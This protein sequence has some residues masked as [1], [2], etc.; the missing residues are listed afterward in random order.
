[1]VFKNSIIEG[2]YKDRYEYNGEGIDGTI[3][4]V[5]KALSDDTAHEGRLIKGMTEGKLFGAGRVMAGAGIGNGVTL[6]NCFTSNF[7]PDSMRGIFNSVSD[8]AMVH[9]LGGGNGNEFSHIR[10]NGSVTS[11]GAVASGVV[12]FMDVF[13]AQTKT[14]MVGSRRGANMGVLSV[15]HPD[16]FEY[17]TAKSKD[18]NRLT[19]FNLSVMVD[20][21][22]MEAVDNNET[23]TLRFPVYNE[24]G[25]LTTSDQWEFTKVVDANEIWDAIMENA[26]NYGEPG[27]LYYD[28]MNN[29]NN[30]R[31]LEKIVVTNPCGEFISGVLRDYPK[32][33]GCCN[34]SS[35]YLHMFVE[36]PFTKDA[37]FNLLEMKQSAEDIV[38]MLD[39]VVDRNNYPDEHFEQYQQLLRTLGVGTTGLGT[40]LQMMGYAYG[41]D[42]AIAFVDDL[43]NEIAK[44]LYRASIKLAK[45]KGSFELFDADKFC[46]SKFLQSHMTKDKEWVGIVNDIKKYGIRNARLISIAP[47][48]TTSMAFGNNCSSGIE[49]VFMHS[50]TRDM[51][52]GGQTEDDKVTVT[53]NDYGY[54][55]YLEKEM[56]QGKAL[57]DI[58]LP[59]HFVTAMELTVHQHVDMLAAIAQH[60]DMAISK[61][62]NVPEDYPF[63]DAKD[64][65]M[66]AWKKGIKGVTIFRPNPLRAGIFNAPKK[67]EEVEEVKQVGL[68]WGTTIEA[69]DDL[70]GRKRK[71]QTGCGSLHIHAFF[72]P[73]SG[74]LMEVF[75]NKGGSGG[76][77]GYAGGL[78]RIISLALRT[79]AT[80][81]S[82]AEQLNS[83]MG[84][85]SYVVRNKVFGD[86]ARGTNCSGAIGN[87]LKQ[88]QKEI[89]EEM[90]G[91]E[92]EDENR[93][94]LEEVKRF[95][96]NAK[97]NSTNSSI[98]IGTGTPKREIT[99]TQ[100]ASCGE[101]AYTNPDGCG[102]CTACGYSKCS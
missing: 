61:T 94:P 24:D 100:C 36:K 15:Y 44:A 17:V 69:S 98:Q 14:V 97:K 46:E 86:T 93:I 42:D 89:F 67:E 50:Y 54:G 9:K 58:V 56:A 30:T 84:C 34:L 32:A 66:S 52:V 92:E 57:E 40:T 16:I 81:D 96:E 35:L 28:N 49:P 53:M 4:R 74:D 60:V 70:I 95:A 12:S 75:F 38:R 1:M 5:A 85:P 91:D 18:E 2:L 37:Y 3:S 82:V 72:D 11:T 27:I 64:I 33:K 77:F 87:V 71:I 23:V 63:E 102:Y 65:Y 13:D 19:Q 51:K 26:Y 45:E 31:Y 59:D 55:I 78:S 88:M 73:F 80:L 21:K 20:D 47:S 83:V 6:N 79:G 7:V 10:P 25:T 41:S 90:N 43:Y 22:F 101:M 62:I 29:M 8:N 99:F 76:C 68:P 39:N 48:G